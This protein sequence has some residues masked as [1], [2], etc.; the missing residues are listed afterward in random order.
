ML[1]LRRALKAAR[2]PKAAIAV[3]FAAIMARYVGWKAELL[4]VVVAL[5]E[6]AL[7]SESTV[8]VSAAGFEMKSSP[9][10]E[11]YAIQNGPGPAAFVPT[12]ELV[13][14]ETMVVLFV[15]GVTT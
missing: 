1:L 2:T 11:S 3:A 9:F 6:V 8:T 7:A 4:E 13:E 15:L 12:T 10:A 5:V 14:S